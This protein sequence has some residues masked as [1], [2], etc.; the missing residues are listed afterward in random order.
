MTASVPGGI[1]CVLYALFDRQERIDHGLMRSQIEAV[2]SVGVSG[3]T[4]LGL[5]TEVSKLS[6]T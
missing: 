6:V 2:L 5:A 1:H 4:V 3:A